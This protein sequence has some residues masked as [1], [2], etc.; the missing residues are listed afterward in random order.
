MKAL[1]WPGISAQYE[2]ET[3]TIISAWR[4]SSTSASTSSCRMHSAVL[5]QLLQH[6]QNDNH[7]CIQLLFYIVNSNLSET[8]LTISAVAPF[9]TGLQFMISAFILLLLWQDK[10]KVMSFLSNPEQPCF[11]AQ[12]MLMPDPVG[13]RWIHDAAPSVLLPNR[14]HKKW[15]LSCFDRNRW[16][17]FQ[18]MP[19]QAIPN[20]L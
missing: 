6:L 12:S 20:S 18:Q 1:Y 4:N 15:S 17:S 8:S 9:R 2:G 10:F 5:W 14:N 3:E 11:M 7:Q 19:D 13:R 16:I